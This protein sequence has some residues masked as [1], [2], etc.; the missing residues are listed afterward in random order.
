MYLPKIIGWYKMNVSREINSRF[1]IT[2]N[3][4]WQRNYYEHII[5]D[6]ESLNNITEYIEMN[7]QLWKKDKYYN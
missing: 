3:S 7:P 6:Q 5:R 4:C 2:G 1:E